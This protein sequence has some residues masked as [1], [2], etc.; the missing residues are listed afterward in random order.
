MGM[1]LSA[2]FPEGHE[3]RLSACGGGVS[4]ENNVRVHVAAMEEEAL[5]TISLA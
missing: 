3:L 4:Q 2:S 1:P 5:A